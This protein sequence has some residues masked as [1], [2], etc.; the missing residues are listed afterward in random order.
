[1][2]EGRIAL[3]LD[4][5]I[6]PWAWP[7]EVRTSPGRRSRHQELLYGFAPWVAYEFELGRGSGDARPWSLA[8]VASLDIV[9]GFWYGTARE[10]RAD[11]S[12]SA[13]LRV[14][15]PGPLRLGLRRSFGR[16]ELAGDW[17]GDVSCEF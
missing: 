9:D 16:D 17:K 7:R 15:P 11:L 4:G 6:R 1:M 12:P 10:P 2:R 13:G 5:W 8:P 3:G 14:S